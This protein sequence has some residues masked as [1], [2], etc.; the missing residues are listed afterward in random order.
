VGV[1]R[2][3]VVARASGVIEIVDEA[4]GRGRHACES[5][6]HLAPGWTATLDGQG[7]VVLTGPAAPRRVE[8]TGV[9]AVEIEPGWVSSAY[10]VRDRAPRIRASI[11]AELPITISYRILPA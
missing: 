11:T 3:I 7:A 2:R 1:R 5:L 6:L 8:F 4:T 9:S 10:G